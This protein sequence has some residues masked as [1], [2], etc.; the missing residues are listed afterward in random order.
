MYIICLFLKK[1]HM[2]D[3]K[4]GIFPLSYGYNNGPVFENK[5]TLEV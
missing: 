3:V 1:V 4:I 2:K 5:S